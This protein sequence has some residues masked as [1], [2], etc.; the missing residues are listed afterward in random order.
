M[1]NPEQMTLFAT[2]TINHDK[3]WFA[4]ANEL[5]TYKIYIWSNL[6]YLLLRI[7]LEKSINAVYLTHV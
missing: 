5:Q 6:L 7:G 1:N 2:D 4:H 3:S